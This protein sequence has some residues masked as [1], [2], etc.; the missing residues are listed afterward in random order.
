[1]KKIYWFIVLLFLGM[2]GYA[3]NTVIKGVVRDTIA[4]SKI[5]KA[6]VTLFGYKDS[7]LVK[8][9][10]TNAQGEFSLEG[11]KDGKYVVL[12]AHPLFA[13]SSDIIEVKGQPEI[14][15]GTIPVFSPEY[16]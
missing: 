3:Q 1:M 15:L 4:D 10:R 16:F 9:T 11:I 7:L 5:P 6:S 8:F 2:S 14:N 12:I 13:S